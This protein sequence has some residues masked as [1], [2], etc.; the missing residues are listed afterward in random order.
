MKV[1]EEFIEEIFLKDYDS[2]IYDRIALTVDILLLS[3]TIKEVDNYRKLSLKNYS[4]LLI[5]RDDCF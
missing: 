3:V 5:K 4:V 1:A 2:S